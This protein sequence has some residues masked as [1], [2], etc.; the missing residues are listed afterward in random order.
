MSPQAVSASL[1]DVG[2]KR[3]NNQDSCGE[4]QSAA[5][6]LLV[7]CDGMGGHQGGEIASRLA[8]E[9]IGQVFS[10]GGAAPEALLRDAFQAAH[11]RVRS[12][13]QQ[14]PELEGMGTTGVALLFD[15]QASA[16]VAHV[17]DSRAYRVRDGRIEQLTND[18]SIVSELLRAGRI[19]PDQ[20]AS[21]PHNELS[22]AL[23]ARAELEVDCAEHAVQDGDRFLLCSDGLW[24][25]VAD[26]EIAEVLLREDPPSAVHTL[27]ARAN[28]RGGTDNVTVQVLGFGEARAKLDDS[29]STR[30]EYAAR[31]RSGTRSDETRAVSLAEVDVDA[32]WESAQRKARA[33]RERRLRHALVAALLVSLLLVVTLLWLVSSRSKI[34]APEAPAEAPAEAAPPSPEPGP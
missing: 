27:V 1:S 34:P 3:K 21:H 18:H 20:A 26:L 28:E 19:T 2:R 24:N 16:W 17:G 30:Q 25:L 7:C 14:R 29:E 33:A 32:I 22:R 6:R 4:F 9:T 31:A 10:R 8:V 11:A 12:E 15:G 5:G 13:A 23:G